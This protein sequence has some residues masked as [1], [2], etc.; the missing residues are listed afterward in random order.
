MSFGNSLISDFKRISA[1]LFGSTGESGQSNPGLLEIAESLPAYEALFTSGAITRMALDGKRLRPILVICE[2]LNVCNQDCVFCPYSQQTREK[3]VM[4]LETFKTVVDQYVAMGGG[5]MSLT[6]IVGDVLLDRFLMQRLDIL[7]AVKDVIQPTVTTNLVALHRLGDE[8]VL[9]MLRLFRRIHISVYGTTAE[10]NLAATRKPHFDD[11][12][13]SAKR[14]MKLWHYSNKACEL[15]LGFRNINNHSDG[16]LAE[17]VMKVFGEELSF[18]AINTYANWGNSISGM[19]PGDAQWAEQK[20]NTTPCVLLA[21]AL[22]VFWDGRVTACSC[23]DYDASEQLTLGN[24]NESHLADIYNGELSQ[25]LWVN[26]GTEKL[27]EICRNCTFHL[28]LKDLSPTH[29]LVANP[30]EFIGG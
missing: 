20:E 13:R 1:K 8:D 19:L 10:E 14:L 17:F 28:P 11:F 15:R 3:G 23:C 7:E 12:V 30:V 5:I 27:P 26:H 29:S 16:E 4:S 25:R 2:T 24:V 22:Q 9:K 6:P 18:T 21:N